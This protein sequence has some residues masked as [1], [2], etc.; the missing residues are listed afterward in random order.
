VLNAERPLLP[1]PEVINEALYVKSDDLMVGFLAAHTLHLYIQSLRGAVARK[2]SDGQD[3]EP[4]LQE[5][6][7]A[8]GNL[9]RF[10]KGS[11]DA[12]ALAVEYGLPAP[13]VDFGVPPMLSQSFQ[14]IARAQ[15]G[16]L[17]APRS[18]ACRVTPALT[19]VRPWL[20]WRAN[21][22]LKPWTLDPSMA[23]GEVKSWPKVPAAL[24]GNPIVQAIWGMRPREM[25]L[26]DMVAA[27]GVSKNALLATLAQ[28]TAPKRTARPAVSR[29]A[30]KKKKK[31]TTTKARKSVTTKRRTLIGKRRITA[32]KTAKKKTL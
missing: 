28:A 10:S 1:S 23:L 22:V 26:P 5:M 30:A 11:P 29:K 21:Q 19:A 31:T 32:R 13:E 8:I 24:A 17:M 3:P 16:T 6:T 12:G 15:D 14:M 20:V 18:Y 7:I 2:L 4:H 9:L 25:S 27:T